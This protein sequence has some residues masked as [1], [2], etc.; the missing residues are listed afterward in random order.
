MPEHLGRTL[1]AMAD[2]GIDALVLGRAGNITFVSG[3]QQL[4]LAGTRPFAPACVVVRATGRV[5]LMSTTDAG[6]P[7]EIPVDQLYGM[8]WNPLTIAGNVAALPGLAEAAVIGVDGITPM[9][10]ALLG[11]ILPGAALVDGEAV[12]RAVRRPKSAGDLHGIRTAV[13]V[14]EAC[15]AAVA[16][17]VAPG[18]TE[19]A[20]LGRFEARRGQMGVTN[21][22]FDAVACVAG[23]APRAIVSDRV[24][25]TGDLVH[26]RGGVLA[27]GWQGVL[28]RTR[29]VDGATGPQIAASERAAAA[30]GEAVAA[31]RPGEVIAE[32]RARPEITA[33]EGVGL[34]HE[35]L[36]DDDVLAPDDVV[37]VEVLVDQVLLGDMV[38]VTDGGPQILTTAPIPIA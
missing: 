30:L 2:A 18:V 20:L 22:A 38:H 37:Y 10:E 3:A 29:V 8:S 32:L 4:A 25:R 15:L 7:A 24:L 1:S 27:G 26:L 23:T 31:C 12:L 6:I 21:P 17:A 33:L 9:M 13:D 11:G 19:R 34:G 14:A 5:H 35:E 28:A 36:A 16:D